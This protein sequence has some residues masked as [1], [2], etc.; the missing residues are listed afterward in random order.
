MRELGAEAFERAVAAA[1]PLSRQLVA[2]ASEGVDL[3]T[4]EGRARFL[5]SARPLWSA[6]PD[7]MLKRQLL[8]EIASRAALPTDELAST[9]RSGGAVRGRPPMEASVS[10]RPRRAARSV[11]RQPADRLAWLLLLESRWWDTLSA[12]DHRLLCALPDWHGALFR[13]VDRQTAEHGAAPW[14]ALR[15]RMV[16]EDWAAP[17]LALVDGEDPAIEPLEEDL[18]R[19]MSQLR[20]ADEQRAAMRVLGRL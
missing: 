1:V 18:Q 16:E 6:L 9:W 17:A 7:G 2:A 11:M 10:P 15:E 5:A 3:A 20:V 19:S 14:A 13:F 8:G 4:A 12:A